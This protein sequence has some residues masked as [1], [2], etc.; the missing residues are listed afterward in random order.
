[1]RRTW[2]CFALT[3]SSLSTAKASDRILV[4]SWTFP[5]ILS[6]AAER[7]PR[8]LSTSA[9]KATTAGSTARA[10]SGRPAGAASDPA[11]A[12]A[13]SRATAASNLATISFSMPPSTRVGPTTKAAVAGCCGYILYIETAFS[14]CGCAVIVFSP[15]GLKNDFS[16]YYLF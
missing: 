2:H 12:R 11:A 13:S 10:A 16:Q 1:M 6:A 14:H 7:R 5:P 3:R 4:A 9:S 8:D 15:K